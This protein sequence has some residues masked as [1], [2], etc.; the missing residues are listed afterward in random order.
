MEGDTG[1]PV[2]ITIISRMVNL[3][4]D[5]VNIIWAPGLNDFGSSP[6]S[7]LGFFFPARAVVFT[8]VHDH[9]GGGGGSGV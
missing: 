3:L 9:A 5:R 4:L 7:S 6:G 2:W 1:L 8:H